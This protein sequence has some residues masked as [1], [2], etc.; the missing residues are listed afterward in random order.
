MMFLQDFDLHFVHIPGSDMGPTDALSHL[1][2][3][4][5]S[6]DNTNIT[7]LPDD[8]FI[9]AIDTALVDKI[10]SSTP[11]DPLVLNTLQSLS[12]GL[13]LFPCSSFAN[14]HFSDSCLYFKNHLYIPPITRHDLVSSVHSSLAS[15]HGGFFRTYSLLSRDYWWPGMSSFVCCFLAGCTLCQ[16][17]K[18]N[19]HPTVPALSPIPSVCTR[20]FQ[21]L[22]VDLITD[23]LSSHGYDSL[24]VVVNHGL[25]KGVILIP[26][27]KTLDA[28]GVAELFFKNVF[29]CFGLHNYLISDQGPQFASAFAA[30][31]ACIL[32]YNLKLSTAYHPQTDGETE[33]VNQEVETY[34]QMFCQGQP[35]MWSELIPMAEFAHNS[36][37]HLSTQKSP[38]S[39][40]LGYEPRDYPK[41]GQ[42]FLPS[43]DNRLALWDKLEMKHRPHKKKPNNQ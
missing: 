43:L 12:V 17:M 5:I 42:M 3:P 33:Q 28:K 20:L 37:T 1:T 10:T 32:K 31:L 24:M 2:D 9:C 11:T 13:P 18:V 35:D 38:F 15:G 41:I 26:C 39:L 4:D 29:L 22:S 23:L 40:I 16:Q 25:L 19:T 14:W 8:L 21:Q 34:L 27:N 30:E 7:F 36:A 6:S